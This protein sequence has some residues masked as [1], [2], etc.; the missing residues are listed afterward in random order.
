MKEATAKERMDVLELLRREESH[1]DLY[2]CGEE[3]RVLVQAVMEAEAATK[4]GASFGER[5][6]VRTTYR[7]GDRPG[8]GTPAWAPW[9]CRSRR[10][11][12]K[13]LPLPAR[14][15]PA[16]RRALLAVV[17]Q[18]YVEGVSTRRVEDLV[19]ALGCEGISKSQVS[20]ICQE[21]GAVVDSSSAVPGAAGP[22]A[23]HVGDQDRMEAMI[24]PAG[25]A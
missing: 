21:L 9:H 3:L 15:P 17:Q 24:L 8:F 23:V 6:P 18:A 13:L 25:A 14:T 4:T 7:N 12:R 11:G 10:C 20:R 19:Q 22:L 1:G 16:Q 5:S 2:S